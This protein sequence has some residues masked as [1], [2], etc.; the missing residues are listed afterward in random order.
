MLLCGN[1]R[2]IIIS[3]WLF[4]AHN[5][6]CDMSPVRDSLPLASHGDVGLIIFRWPGR[7]SIERL[8]IL[9]AGMRLVASRSI[10]C[11]SLVVLNRLLVFKFKD[12]ARHL[13]Y[14]EW[15]TRIIFRDV[16]RR[17]RFGVWRYF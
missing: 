17:V 4:K 7:D 3:I 16:C 1:C 14:R 2:T 5:R 6:F 9:D 12:L 15:L 11:A 8:C 10:H 13:R